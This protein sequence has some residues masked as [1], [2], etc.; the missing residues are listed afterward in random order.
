MKKEQTLRKKALTDEDKVINRLK[1][2]RQEHQSEMCRLHA[3]IRSLDDV[4]E[5]L[6][7]QKNSKI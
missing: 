2:R 6:T 1:E 3:K 7:H 5:D 4:I